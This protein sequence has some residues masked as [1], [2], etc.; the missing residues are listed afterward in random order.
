MPPPSTARPPHG[1]HRPSQW[2]L[3]LLGLGLLA[4]AASC[5][6]AARLQRIRR[7]DSVA[8]EQLTLR[9]GLTDPALMTEARHVRH[10]S[11]TDLHAPFQDHP[12]AFDLFPGGTLVP[13][14]PH[15]LVART[16]ALPD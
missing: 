6:D 8:S 4:F 13:P 5:V 15:A 16:S 11:Q 14:P 10:R 12:F 9:F 3:G 7:A 1:R 2:C